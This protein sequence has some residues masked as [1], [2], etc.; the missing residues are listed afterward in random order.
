MADQKTAAGSAAKMAL[1][2]ISGLILLTA[3][4][5]LIWIWRLDVLSIIRGFLGMAV[6]LAGVIFLAIAKE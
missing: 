2:V 6:A 4:V 3:G 1:K 5:A